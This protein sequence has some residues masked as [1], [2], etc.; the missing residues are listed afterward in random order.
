MD[1]C[2]F[3]QHKTKRSNAYYE[4]NR[5]RRR[6]DKFKLA[7]RLKSSSSST[8]SLISGANCV[9]TTHLS[10]I[11]STTS[12]MFKIV[13]FLLS[14]GVVCSSK[15]SVPTVSA[16]IKDTSINGVEG[17]NLN[18]VIPYKF[19]DYLFGLKYTVGDFRKL[20]DQLFAR[21]SF[22]TPLDGVVTFDTELSVEDKRLGL[23]VDWDSEALDFRASASVDSIDRLKSGKKKYFSLVQSTFLSHTVFI[24]HS[25]YGQM[26]RL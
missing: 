9:K 6:T 10:P 4:R 14:L 16:S 1:F 15:P 21:K 17:L 8:H 19:Q 5:I 26:V 13:L 3:G 20:P 23:N 24:L 2:F 12:N 22:D 18:V 25:I 7:Q 11:K